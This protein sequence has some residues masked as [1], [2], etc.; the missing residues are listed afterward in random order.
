[1]LDTGNMISGMHQLFLCL[2]DRNNVLIEKTW[3]PWHQIILLWCHTI[4]M[5]KMRMRQSKVE[6]YSVEVGGYGIK[7][8]S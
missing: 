6:L 7:K 3:C 1:M 5:M 8:E 4:Q 2:I